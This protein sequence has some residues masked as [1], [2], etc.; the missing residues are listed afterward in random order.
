ML[1]EIDSEELTLTDLDPVL[2]PDVD[3]EG[4][5]AFA[6]SAAGEPGNP[7]FNGHLNTRNMTLSVASDLKVS[8][9]IDLDFGG[10]LSRPSV[11]GNI[12]ID[13]AL[14]VLPEMKESL[15]EVDGESVLWEA[16]DSLRIASDTSLVG[17]AAD[18]RALKRA[19]ETKKMDLDVTITL[20]PSSF[21][22][23]SEKLNLELE[24]T[25]HL[26]QDGD[27]P[28]ITGELRP[29]QGRLTFM[30]RYFEIQRGSVF[31]YGGD[32]MNPSFDL[33]L[34]AHVSEYDIRIKLTGTA[35]KP[36]IELTSNPARSESDI[37]SLL[38][39]GQVMSDLNGSQANLLQQR[40]TEVLMVFGATKL[41]SEMKKRLG[42]DMFTFQ[43]ST[44]VPNETALMVGK[45]LNRR[46]MLKYEQG[47]E[48]T[49][50]FLINL[51][52]HLTRRFTIETFIDQDSETGLEINW[53]NEY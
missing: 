35:L 49:A 51:E 29:I 4:F 26:G 33:T 34:T 40:T 20:P 46:T 1:L 53:S 16:A 41:E 23:E 21:R 28:I 39:F 6:L 2:P 3:L 10:D 11:K 45:Y 19:E 30:G 42:V 37:M 13:R 8:P 32:E 36:E 44:R 18:T 17:S 31:F 25:L 48:N 50:S 47:L 22:V 7:R 14:L 27:R 15:L 9:S 43:Q 5:A 12:V 24:G 38:L 52:Y